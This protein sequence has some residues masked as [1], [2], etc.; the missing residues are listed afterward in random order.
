MLQKISDLLNELSTLSIKN[1][2]ELETFRLKYLS[3]KGIIS[4]LFEDFKNVDA[5]AKKEIG[6]KLNLLK[7]SASEKYNSLKSE[8]LTNESVSMPNDLTR[9]SFPFPPVPV[10]LFLL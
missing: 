1:P 5:A 8:L 4:D 3:K 2:E 7:Q 9:P 6:Q 10:I